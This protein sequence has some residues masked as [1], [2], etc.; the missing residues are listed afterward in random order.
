MAEQTR[1]SECTEPKTLDEGTPR[2]PLSMAKEGERIKTDRPYE[3]M[4]MGNKIFTMKFVKINLQHS[5]A[6]TAVLSR[7][8]KTCTYSGTLGSTN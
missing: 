5:K 4:Q 7:K 3:R 1:A 2:E 8:L 6:A